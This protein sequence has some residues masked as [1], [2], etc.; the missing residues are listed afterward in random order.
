MQVQIVYR[1]GMVKLFL[2][3][4]EILMHDFM[5]TVRSFGKVKTTRFLPD[6]DQEAADLL[7]KSGSATK[8]GVYYEEAQKE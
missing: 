1:Q 5:R 3:P 7:V 6:V 2:A 4:K 8:V